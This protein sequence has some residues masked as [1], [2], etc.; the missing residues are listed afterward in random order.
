MFVSLFV[1]Q[2]SE[3]KYLYDSQ[4]KSRLEAAYLAKTC[5]ITASLLLL[6]SSPYMRRSVYDN[7]WLVKLQ[8][9]QKTR[10]PPLAEDSVQNPD[11]GR[12][13]KTKSKDLGCKKYIKI[14][15]RAALLEVV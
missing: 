2:S 11:L 12:Q 13:F 7:R 5:E 10:E 6:L 14:P 3:I 9:A 8:K 4:Q 15:P 1:C